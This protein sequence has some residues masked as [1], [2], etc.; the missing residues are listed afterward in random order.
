MGTVPAD[1]IPSSQDDD[2]RRVYANSAR[3][4]ATP[5][6][7]QITFGQVIGAEKGSPTVLDS[8]TAIL[9]PPQAKAFGELLRKI[10]DDYE[11]QFG[12]VPGHEVMLKALSVKR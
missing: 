5:W 9:S 10:M 7:I 6:D 11:A 1:Q 12:P 3:I 4:S 8:M 2:Y